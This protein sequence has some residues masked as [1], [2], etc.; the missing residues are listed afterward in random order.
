MPSF[1]V[2]PLPK[3]LAPYP[4]VANI[5]FAEGPIFDDDG[6]LY[7]VNYMVNGTLGR[8]S[9]DGTTEIWVHTGGKANGLKY[10]GKGHVVVADPDAKRVTRFDTRTRRMEVL[11]DGYE[12]QKYNGPNDVSMDLKGSV[13]FSDPGRSDGREFG[14]VYRIDFDADNNPTIVTRLIDEIPVPN[15]HAVH[16]GQKQFFL[17]VTGRNSIISF[18]IADDGS[19]K[20][21]QTVYQFPDATVDGIQFDEHNRLW[22]ARW[23]HGTVAVLDVETGELLADYPMGGDR[24]TNMAWWGESIYIT[25]AGRHSIERLDVGCRGADIVPR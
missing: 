5:D 12:G 9:P 23:L 6:N 24:V 25:V 20:N 2:P 4:V 3:T 22:V 19:L 21:E 15:G 18:D 13:Y 10:D 17:A 1:K 7:F 11:T 8:M 14:G 16:P